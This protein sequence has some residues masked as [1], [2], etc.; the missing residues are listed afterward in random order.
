VRPTPDSAGFTLIE[1]VV[2]LALFAIIAAAGVALVNT[3]L[4]AQARTAGRLDRVGDL[5]RAMVV[6]G[7]DVTEIA[8]APLA[9]GAAS[10]GFDRH[11]GGGGAIGVTYRLDGEV[12]ERIANGRTQVVLDHVAGVRWRYYAAPG[13]WQDRWPATVVQ[14]RG[15]PVAVAVEVDLAGPGLGGTLR[16]VVDLPVRPLPPGAVALP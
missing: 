15:W 9:G 1:V 12:L 6:I 2:A 11:A 5:S 16:R 4:D 13:G 3:V 7:R 14:A 8:D 10:I